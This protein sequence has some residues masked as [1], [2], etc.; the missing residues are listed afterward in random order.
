MDELD[1]L[2]TELMQAVAA[3]AD[4]DGLEAARVAALGRRG[5]L[6][7]R[8]KDV[9]RLAPEAR[10]TEGARLNTLKDALALAIEARKAELAQAQLDARLD[11]SRLDVTLPVRP[12]ARGRIHPISQTVDEVVALFGEMGFAVAEGPDIEG[13]WA[14]WG[15]FRAV[16][17][18]A[19]ADALAR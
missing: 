4:L 5:T 7:A 13:D 3:A 9:G 15:R 8:L 2:R 12:E 16:V 17:H 10:R 14:D 1:S 6:T 19:V 11:E 18:R